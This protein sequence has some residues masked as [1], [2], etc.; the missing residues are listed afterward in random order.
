MVNYNAYNVVM[1]LVGPVRA[2]GKHEVDVA[3][4][5]NLNHLTEVVD[6][7]L[8]EISDAAEAANRQEASMKAIGRR[9]TEYLRSVHERQS[10]DQQP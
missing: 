4:L 3:R 8:Q 2:V 7:L 6:C 9:A 10:G 5:V 1:E